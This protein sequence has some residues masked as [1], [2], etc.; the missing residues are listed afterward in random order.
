LRFG[1]LLESEDAAGPE[2]D[3]GIAEVTVMANEQIA[4]QRVDR[5]ML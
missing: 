3:D 4:A 5:F 1:T 2:Y